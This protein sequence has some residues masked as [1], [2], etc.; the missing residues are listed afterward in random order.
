MFGLKVMEISAIS[1]VKNDPHHGPVIHRVFVS[2][3]K[4]FKSDRSDGDIDEC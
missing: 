3:K 1:Q 2:N 4:T